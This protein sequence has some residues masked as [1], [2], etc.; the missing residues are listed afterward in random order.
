M[1]ATISHGTCPGQ[2]RFRNRGKQAGIT[3]LEVL[4]AIF[5]TGIGLLALL[6]LFPLGALDMAEA[7]K[8][9]R[10]A[11][12]A[13][14]AVALSDAGKD[15]LSQTMEFVTHSLF[16]G[17]IDPKIAA[18]LLDKYE[19]L[20]AQSA[21]LKADLQELKSIFSPELVERYVD[22]LL[23]EIRQIQVRINIIIKLLWLV[24]NG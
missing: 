16:K 15:V 21:D 9:D 14:R 23:A 17:S 20:A 19:D 18:D 22:P 6:Q 8:D 13:A 11:A 10:T 4:V 3:L 24:S 5:I 2:A 7:I 1:R 12:V